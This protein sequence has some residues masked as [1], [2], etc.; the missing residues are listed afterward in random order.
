M[1]RNHKRSLAATSTKLLAA[2][3]EHIGQAVLITDVAGTVQYVNSAFTGMTGYSAEEMVGQNPRLLKSGRQDPAYYRELWRT[4]LAGEVWRGELLNRRKDGS[5]Y[6]DQMSITPVRDATGVV[7]NFIAI[8]A[9]IS[10]NRA[11]QSA[12]QSSETRF[13]E[14]QRIAPL[15]SW[16]LD[17]EAGEVRG[18]DGFLRIFEY[19]PGTATLR[20]SVLLEA[21]PEAD[22]GRIQQVLE[23]TIRTLE[24]FDVKHRVVRRDGTMRTVRSRGQVLGG[25][26]NEPRRVCGTI[27]DITESALAYDKLRMSEEKF[28]SL[29]ANIPDVIWSASAGGQIDYLSANVE[30]LSG[31]TAEEIREQGAA[32]WFNRIHPDDAQS[33]AQALQRL[34]TEG[35]HFDLDY[36]AQRKDGQWIWVHEKAYRTYERDGVRFADGLSS[37]ITQRKRAVEVVQQSERFLQSTLDA[38]SSHVAIINEDGVIAAANAAW[39]RFA[40]AN[41]GEANTCGVGI[42]YINVCDRSSD[43]SAEAR[44]AGEGLR[45]L[46]AGEL[47]EFSIEYPCHSPDVKRWF[48][49]RATPFAEGGGKV[50]LAHENITQRKLA[51]EAVRE[52][53]ERYRSLFERNMA[54]VYRCTVDGRLLE[55]NQSLASMFGYNSPDEALAQPVTDW[56]YNASERAEFLKKLKSDKSVTSYEMRFRRKDGDSFWVIGNLTLI[57]DPSSAD[58]IIEGTLVDISQRKWVEEELRE[59]G[60]QIRLVLDS[61]PEAVYGIDMKGDCTFCSPSCLQL[62]RYQE[63]AELLGKNMHEVM[64]HTRL[65]GSH[66]PV[67]ECHIY[68]AFRRG[69]GTHIDDEIL[70]RRDGTS[71]PGEYWSHPM[72]RDGK[73][74]GAVVTFLD[75][76]ERKRNE[77]IL[78]EAREA[79]EAANRAKSQF[80][81]NMSHEIRTPMNGVIGVAG[82]LLDTQLTEEQREYAEIIRSSGEGLMKVINDILDFSKIEARKFV[83]E[84]TDFDLRTVLQ[85]TTA[86]LALRASEKGVSLTSELE[87]GTPCLLRG[88]PGRL[89]QILINLVGNAVKF[90]HQGSVSLSAR[91]ENPDR[92]NADRGRATLRFNVRDTGIGFRQDRASTLF[93]PFVQA[94]G[95][96]T[97]RY[98]GTGLGLTISRQLCEMMGGQIGAESEEGKGSTFWFTAVFD[99]QAQSSVRSVA[100]D[101]GAAACAAPSPW[102]DLEAGEKSQARILLAEDNAINQKVAI[103]ILR[104]AGYKADVVANGIEALRALAETDY[105][106]VLMD[107]EM[108]EMDGFEATRRIRDGRAPTRNPGI[109]VIAVTAGAMAGDRDRCLQAGMSDYM[110][111]PIG[112]LQLREILKKWLSPNPSDR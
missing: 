41:G 68:E 70:W 78:R 29:V 32:L 76:T 100:R 56:W 8:K 43:S 106:L 89:R 34:F 17:V 73:I 37:D 30:Q 25:S 15:G 87:R 28:R 63:S 3:M 48:V 12:L 21:V 65:D 27:L 53:E 47:Q 9:D 2:A 81:A 6:L 60:E 16:E 109:T 90:T 98:G 86:L 57:D 111:K 77:Q 11:T 72:H 13:E 55:C 39:H 22:R 52:S 97:R 108:P 42:N 64:H 104:K 49:M 67:E 20:L 33:T 85:D 94:D 36:R 46:I 103:A 58:G 14:V 26:G 93:E 50:V 79:A 101:S 91:L 18:S 69:E 112:S 96:S 84:T 66:Y 38:L 44:R 83:L 107:C 71:F 19:P 24:P 82:L 105:D 75:I 88:D 40:A 4:I 80:L 95:T 10:E 74:V 1:K 61:I 54:G 51:E 62:L 7:T 110:T 92:P 35:R 59:S 5:L 102:M 45:R 99:T 31:F 23:E